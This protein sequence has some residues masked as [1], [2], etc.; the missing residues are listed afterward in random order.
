MKASE[1]VFEKWSKKYKSSINC[2]HPRGVSQK[3]HC[4]GKNKQNES[5]E[6]EMVCEAC[7]M[8]QTHGNISEIKKGAKDSN[9][10][11]RCWPGKHAEGTKTGKNG[12]QVR[13]CVPNESQGVAEAF[14]Q[15]Y[16]LLRWEKGDFGDV[17]AIARLDDNTFLSIMFNKGFGKDTKE[18]TWSVE[19]WRNNSQEVTGEGDSQRVFATVLS[20]IQQFIDTEH[21]AHIRFSAN[22]DVDPGQKSQTRSNLYN[23]LVQRYANSWGYSVDVDDFADTTVYNLYTLHESVTENFAEGREEFNQ[24]IMRPG[25]EFSQEIAG[26]TYK[27]TNDSGQL[28]VTAWDPEGKQIGHSVFW[29]HQTRSGLESLSTEVDKDWQR[30]GIAANMYAVVRMLGANINP[31]LFQSK[32][33]KNMWKKWQQQGDVAQLKHMNAKIK[34][35]GVPE[36]KDFDRC[37]DQACKLYDRAVSKNLEPKLVQVADFQGDGNG[38]DPR[39][40]KLPQH[41][42]QHY[43]VIVG[44]Q[45]LDPTAKQFGDSMPTQY[46]VSDLD[47]L[48]GKQYQIRPRQG[49][50]ENFADGKV[51]GKSRPGRVKRAGA[52]CAGSVTDLRARAKN[53]S[54]EK[55]RMY[56]WCANMKSGRKK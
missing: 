11:T 39:W 29:K 53:A 32:R 6:M 5:V 31:S 46:Q 34:E 36:G 27:V 35:Q 1:F 26:V 13:N 17:D 50:A 37:F 30:K 16:P 51:K 14:D 3:A 47:R 20:A 24:E 38:A 28:M 7:G 48:W 40:M 19:F 56:H 9:G 10:Y 2:S 43:V 15:P 18:E 49:M 42:W 52:S 45:V 41:V 12:G 54:G 25:F 4:A 22:K 44:D 55:A 21:P 33:G 23:K 8:C